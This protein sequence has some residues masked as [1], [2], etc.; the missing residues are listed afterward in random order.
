MGPVNNRFVRGA[1]RRFYERRPGTPRAIPACPPGWH[2]GAP[3]FVGIGVQ[4][5]GTTWWFDEVSRHPDVHLAPGAPKEVH[6]FDALSHLDALD[7]VEQ[8]HHWFPRPAGGIT[9]EWT[10]A[11]IYDP[12]TAPLLVQAAPRARLLLMLRDPLDR[13]RSAVPFLQRRGFA[14]PEAARDA[15]HRGL[16]AQQVRRILNH[17]AHERLLVLTYEE[18]L[19]NPARA[20]HT[21]AGF[22]GLDPERFAGEVSVRPPNK[23]ARGK[24]ELPGALQGDVAEAYRAD[25]GQLAALLP[26][27]DFG[28]WPSARERVG[29]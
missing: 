24:R 8:Y 16:Y 6:F 10:P 4:R 25:I 22:L 18:V 26:T 14:H 3:D 2:T 1:R 13:L 20:R 21:T 17:V 23:R 7:D 15:F 19:E 28:R 12:W 29:N 9:G 5:A 11:Y 27:V